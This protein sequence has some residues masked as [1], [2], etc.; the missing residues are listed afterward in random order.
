[1]LNIKCDEYDG[2]YSYYCYNCG[3]THKMSPCNGNK[4]FRCHNDHAIRVE[5]IE[6]IMKDNVKFS[7]FIE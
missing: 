4:L 7:N 3:I 2:C 5:C 6:K 1:M